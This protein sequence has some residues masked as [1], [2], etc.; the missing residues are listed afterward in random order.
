MCVTACTCS[1]ER[2]F[3]L[4]PLHVWEVKR[5]SRP[6]STHNETQTLL[7]SSRLSERMPISSDSSVVFWSVCHVVSWHVRRWL[8]SPWYDSLLLSH[9]SSVSPPCS[10]HLMPYSALTASQPIQLKT[11][12]MRK[13]AT[14]VLSIPSNFVS[15]CDNIM[16]QLLSTRNK[17]YLFFCISFVFS[18]TDFPL[19]AVYLKMNMSIF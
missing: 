10:S 8:K 18:S 1:R 14:F 6:E 15:S 17:P 5:S 2:L 9:L 12:L 19:R 3:P 13:A 11:Y 16:S 4:C 7:P